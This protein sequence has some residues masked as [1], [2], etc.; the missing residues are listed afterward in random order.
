MTYDSH[1]R[2][3]WTF[4]HTLEDEV[5][6]NTFVTTETETFQPF[7]E[8]DL[9]TQISSSR[10]A[11]VFDETPL[12]AVDVDFM[13]GLV[14]GAHV[15]F[16]YYSPAVLPFVRHT[17][18]RKYTPLIAPVISKASTTESSGIETVTDGEWILVERAYSSTQNCLRLATYA[19]GALKNYVD[20]EPYTPGNWIDVTVG[21]FKSSTYNQTCA[22]VEING[23]AANI[24]TIDDVSTTTEPLRIN[25]SGFGYTAHKTTQ[26]KAMIAD[27]VLI[28]GDMEDDPILAS[29][30]LSC[31]RIRYGWERIAETGFLDKREY[32]MGVGFTQPTSVSTNHIFVSGGNIYAAR[33]DGKLYKGSRGI[34]DTEQSFGASTTLD[35]LNILD[36]TKAEWTVEGLRVMGTRVR[37]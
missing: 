15:S 11:L 5:S 20:S 34:W 12:Y 2:G 33:S 17:I 29:N 10:R 24:M 27:L 8:T 9:A 25:H 36:D 6:G 26:T 23:A 31:S 13:Y 1:I 7:L 19:V 3:I 37:I 35:H 4:D 32:A 28:S 16:R 30:F 14:Y 22:R 21:I 18:T